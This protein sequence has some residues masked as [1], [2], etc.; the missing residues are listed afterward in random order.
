VL[1]YDPVHELSLII[2]AF[3]TRIVKLQIANLKNSRNAERI[4]ILC[5]TEKHVH[6]L[7]QARQNLKYKQMI[8]TKYLYT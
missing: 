2:Y 3:L 4:F 5:D 8:G 6:Y 1:S 7:V